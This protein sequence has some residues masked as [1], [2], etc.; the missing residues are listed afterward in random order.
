MDEME[1]KPSY[2]YG[3]ERDGVNLAIGCVISTVV[4]YILLFIVSVCVNITEWIT[5]IQVGYWILMVVCAVC[6]GISILC[7]TKQELKILD[8]EVHYLYGVLI[9]YKISIPTSKILF[10]Q[11]NKSLLQRA[12]GLSTLGI[13]TASDKYEIYFVDIK[14]GE[15]AYRSIMDM[16]K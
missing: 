14:N 8:T 7:K 5:I 2:F 12:F 11:F 9:K 6:A 4:F 13:C 3:P 15:E 1:K 16:I 10:C